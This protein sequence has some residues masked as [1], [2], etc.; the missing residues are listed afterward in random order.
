MQYSDC[1]GF[2]ASTAF[3]F[4]FYDIGDEQQTPLL[5]HPICLSEDHIR[6]QRYSR[7][8]RQL[9][10]AYQTRL[11]EMNAP[12]VVALSNRSFN[13]RSYNQSFLATLKKLLGYE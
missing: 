12:F 9:F 4:R 5:I 6:Q 7:K 8:M 10:L 2:R 13:S 3:P 11:K 1:S